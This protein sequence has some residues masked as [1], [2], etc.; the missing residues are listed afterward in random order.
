MAV[1]KYIMALI[2]TLKHWHHIKIAHF[3]T[4]CMATMV[5][6]FMPV[7]PNNQMNNHLQYRFLPED[8]FLLKKMKDKCISKLNLVLI[9]FINHLINSCL[10]LK[11]HISIQTNSIWKSVSKKGVRNVNLKENNDFY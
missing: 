6:S 1:T 2:R 3:I 10:N 7:V 5:N 4:G 9:S 8:P 11:N